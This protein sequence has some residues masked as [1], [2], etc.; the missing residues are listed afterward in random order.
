MNEFL[1]YFIYFSNTMFFNRLKKGGVY[2]VECFYICY[3]NTPALNT[4]FDILFLIQA[5]YSGR[6][7]MFHLD[8]TMGKGGSGL[9]SEIKQNLFN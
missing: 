9:I 1:L 4:V 7:P 3:V 6:R 2:Q 8:L 5:E